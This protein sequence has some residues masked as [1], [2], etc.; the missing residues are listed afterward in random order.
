MNRAISGWDFSNSTIMSGLRIYVLVSP[1]AASKLAL[2]A[3]KRTCARP[4]RVYCFYAQQFFRIAIKSGR[5]LISGIRHCSEFPVTDRL[6]LTE[7]MD[8]TVTNLG[9][10]VRHRS[11]ASLH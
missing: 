11:L 9:R 5:V 3:H 8:K 6:Q 4:A 7:N 10:R 2:N 1:K